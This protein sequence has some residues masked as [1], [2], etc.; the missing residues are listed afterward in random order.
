MGKLPGGKYL[1]AGAIDLSSVGFKQVMKD[2]VGRAEM[3]GGEKA[4]KMAASNVDNMDGMGMVMGFPEGGVFAGLLTNTVQ[5]TAAKDPAA[6]LKSFR[7]TL[8][9]MDGQKI[10]N[11]TYQSK[12]TENVSK[13][14][15]TQIDAWETSF[16]AEDGGELP[17][18]M[19]QAM[20]MMFGPQGMPVGY[21]AKGTGGIYSTYAKNTELMGKA[22]DA[23]KGDNLSTDG[24][25]K[26]SQEMLPG[27]RM[28]E[29][30]VGT[31]GILDLALPFAA[32]AGMT[33]PADKIP[34]KL[35]PIA[36]ALSTQDGSLRFTLVLPA[37]VI[38]TGVFLGM[39]TSKAMEGGGGE[40]PA[41]AKQEKGAG[42]PKF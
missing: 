11:L 3:P 7:D 15:E 18:A 39:E 37:P 40:E 20:P 42:Q 5:F 41:K 4:S 26:K 13:V 35:P 14:G 34:E 9:A 24:M 33:V 23:S 25:L 38:K 30:Y 27:N 22:L 10:E 16:K 17:A 12:Y 2:I 32:M 19:T 8:A 29:M 6:A 28:A 1:W 31:K 36:G 21:V